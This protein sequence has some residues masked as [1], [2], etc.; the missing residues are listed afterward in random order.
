M[1]PICVVDRVFAR[2][3]RVAVSVVLLCFRLPLA[4]TAAAAGTVSRL[5][6][7][8]RSLFALRRCAAQ[9][10]GGGC[11]QKEGAG[12]GGGQD[13]GAGRG[14]G[15]EEGAGGGGGQEEGAGGGGKTKAS[16]IDLCDSSAACIHCHCCMELWPL[17]PSL[18]YEAPTAAAIV[19]TRLLSVTL[20]A[21]VMSYYAVIGAK[22]VVFIRTF[23]PG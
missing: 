13:E 23:C 20:R 14:G 7:V 19:A 2:K 21:R 17:P 4:G 15:Q 22:D 8:E 3:P 6:P 16:P 11:G 10:A 1:V 5:L 12:G 18:Y 9:G